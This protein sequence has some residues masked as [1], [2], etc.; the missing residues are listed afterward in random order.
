MLNLGTNAAHAMDAGGI[1]TV[2]LRA[3]T[4]EPGSILPDSKL[5]YGRYVH[6]WV[7]D[8]GRGIAPEYLDRI[9]DPFFTTK[10]VSKGTG[11]GLSVVLGIVNNHKGSIFVKSRPGQGTVF[12]I[13]FPAIEAFISEP[14][15]QPQAL[16]GGQ[17]RILFIDDEKPIAEIARM[18]LQ[19]LGYSVH[20]I[21]DPQQALALFEGDP[22]A[23]DL[24]ITD[25]SMPH[26]T[27]EEVA[28]RMLR[29]RPDLP[30]ILISG[31]SDRMDMHRAKKIGIR[32][33][34]QKPLDRRKLALA[35]RQV[36]DQA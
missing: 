20:S 4:F 36:L 24:V 14:E 18:L 19:R 25:M 13:F 16:P 1:L 7:Q 32:Q 12:D 8:T 35:V 6:L 9:F 34:I 3:V 33:Y 22:Q 15:L 11:L 27:G 10:D 26:V 31:Y 2:G 29:R 5:N 23:V 30:I 17:E 28:L 21:T